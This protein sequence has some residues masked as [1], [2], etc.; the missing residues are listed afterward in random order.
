MMEYDP[1]SGTLLPR[2]EDVSAPP[3]GPFTGDSGYTYGKGVLDLLTQGVQAYSGL[4]AKRIESQER[5][6][7][8]RQGLAQV[9][10]P[11]GTVRG[12]PVTPLMVVGGILLIGGAIWLATR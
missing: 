5:V 11:I 1:L 10:Q 3:P 8:G 2:Y 7:L 6:E 9:G 4:K 12:V